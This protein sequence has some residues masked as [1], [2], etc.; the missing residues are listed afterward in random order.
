[1]LEHQLG[2]VRVEGRVVEIDPLPEGYRN[3]VA[4]RSGERLDAARLPQCQRI[5]VTR[6][7]DDLLPGCSSPT[8]L[9][10][11]RGLRSPPH[12]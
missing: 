4:P 8:P 6:G 3:V 11:V 7:G 12:R 2:P 1:M 9:R 10:D 5:K